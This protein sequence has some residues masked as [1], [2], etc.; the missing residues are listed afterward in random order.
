MPYPIFIK[1]VTMND[2][3]ILHNWINR[4]NGTDPIEFVRWI[5]END[6]YPMYKD[7]HWVDR[8]RNKIANTIQDLFELFKS[9]Q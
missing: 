2:S 7:L 6:Y 5:F 9:Q 4:N 1:N 3:E 8:D